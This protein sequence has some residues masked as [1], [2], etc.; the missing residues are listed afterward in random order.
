M[1]RRR[2]SETRADAPTPW[3]REEIEV[4][5]RL[6]VKVGQ[7]HDEAHAIRLLDH[8]LERARCYVQAGS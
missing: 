4:A 5:R 6:L 3:T 7:P 8:G 2:R 1:R